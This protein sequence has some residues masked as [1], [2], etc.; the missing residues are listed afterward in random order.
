VS[1]PFFATL[2][3]WLFSGELY[4]PFEEFFVSVDSSLGHIPYVHPSSLP[5]GI[6]QLTNNGGFSGFNP[7]A[8]DFSGPQENGLKLWEA[9]YRF[10]KDM[11]PM[12]VGESFGRKVRQIS[13]PNQ[14]ILRFYQIFSTGKSLNFIRYS[15]L[16]SDWVVTREKMSNTGGSE[17]DNFLHLTSPRELLISIAVRR[18]WRTGKIHRYCVSNSQ[19]STIRSLY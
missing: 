5:G 7:D 1:R 15:C 11:L 12:F 10:R 16:D 3:R 6:N 9:K 14:H 18:Y 19:S 2:H 17:S 13:A 8:E 4:D